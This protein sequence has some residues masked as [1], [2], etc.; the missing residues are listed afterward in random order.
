MFLMSRLEAIPR[1]TPLIQWFVLVTFM[2]GARLTLRAD[3]GVF[4]ALRPA[5]SSQH[6]LPVLLVGA[7]DGA[8]LF[9]QALARNPAAQHSAVGILDLSGQHRD[10]SLRNVPVLGTCE[11]L[12]GVVQELDR[13]GRRPQHLIITESANKLGG[14]RMQ[15]LVRDGERLGLVVSRLPAP[16]ELRRAQGG[17]IELRP[18]ELADLLGRPQ[19]QL[20]RARDLPADRGPA[21]ARHRGGRHHRR[22][23]R[24]PDRALCARPS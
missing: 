17:E 6:K 19:A 5:P 21:G 11:E 12:E 13:H 9:L 4:A 1:S 15:W 23:A 18:I 16:T 2:G 3:R 22:R 8:D 20:D 10:R 7:G 24:P 14:A